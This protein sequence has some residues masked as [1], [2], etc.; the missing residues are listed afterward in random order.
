MQHCC[1]F[2]LLC[3][4]ATHFS[5]S[6]RKHWKTHRIY[7]A[8]LSLGCEGRIIL[9]FPSPRPHK[10]G[11]GGQNPKEKKQRVNIY[12]YS[13]WD[14]I[15]LY[16]VVLYCVA[17]RWVA[18]CWVALCCVA[19][20]CIVLYCIVLYWI[21]LNWIEMNWIELKLIEL[22]WMALPCL[23]FKLDLI[24]VIA[25]FRMKWNDGV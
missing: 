22:N 4:K 5:V 21:V 6:K 2:C 18:L 1:V 15:V 19:L 3:W 7:T 8:S 20:R 24:I 17:L 11:A 16:C 9:C 14:I 25:A 12:W 13:I 23:A 10:T